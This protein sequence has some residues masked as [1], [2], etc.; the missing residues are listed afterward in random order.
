[1]FAVD[2]IRSQL[3][4]SINHFFHNGWLGMPVQSVVLNPPISQYLYWYMHSLM[5]QL[6]N[7]DYKIVIALF[8]LIIAV[9]FIWRFLLSSPIRFRHHYSP[10]KIDCLNQDGNQKIKVGLMELI[11][12]DCKSLFRGVFYPTP[13]LLSGHLQTIYAA[14]LGSFFK[15]YRVP[16][17]RV[18]LETSDGGVLSG[19]LLLINY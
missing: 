10:L 7:A 6:M 15:S 14:L 5:Q 18:T 13:W 2:E 8:T 3:I 16:F 19:L 11:E 4:S 12:R 1:M 9:L 17:V